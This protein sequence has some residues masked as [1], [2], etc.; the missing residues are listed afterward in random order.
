[1]FSGTDIHNGNEFEFEQDGFTIKAKAVYDQT[2]DLSWIGEFSDTPEK[3]AIDHHATD[4]WLERSYRGERYFN[5]ATENGELDYKRMLAYA[6]GEWTMIGI[7]VKVFREGIELGSASLWGIE[8]DSGADY[9]NEL[10]TEELMLEALGEAQ[11]N[12]D[13]LVESVQS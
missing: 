4:N 8:S 2:P 13:K 3:G 1:M 12:L 9:F 7:I 11:D 6:H 5:P 10:V